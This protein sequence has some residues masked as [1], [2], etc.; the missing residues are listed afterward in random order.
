MIRTYGTTVEELR[1]WFEDGEQDGN[2]FMLIVHS[3]HNG[4]EFPVF[5]SPNRSLPKE[6][7]RWR[8]LYKIVA[9][10][11]LSR[12]FSEQSDSFRTMSFDVQET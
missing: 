9:E 7:K 4:K 2:D 1:Q 11:D 5:V 10:Y 6:R 12:P 3:L 8:K